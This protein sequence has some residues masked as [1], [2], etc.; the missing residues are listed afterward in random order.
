MYI[1]S[2]YAPNNNNYHQLTVV[3]HML[4]SGNDSNIFLT[5]IGQ[6]TGG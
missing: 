5:I 3:S 1:I 6:T 4:L 2:V